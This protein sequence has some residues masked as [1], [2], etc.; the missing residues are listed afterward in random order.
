MWESIDYSLLQKPTTAVLMLILASSH[1]P[2]IVENHIIS[3]ISTTQFFQRDDL[4]CEECRFETF[5]NEG[6][7]IHLYLVKCGSVSLP[8]TKPQSAPEMKSQTYRVFG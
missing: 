4:R 5:S 8:L 1:S 7:R 2:F 3:A 6:L